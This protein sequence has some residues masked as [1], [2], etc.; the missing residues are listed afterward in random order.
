MSYLQIYRL[1][2]LSEFIQTQSRYSTFLDKV[3]ILTW[4]W[5]KTFLVLT[6]TRNGLKPAETSWNHPESTWNHLNAAIL[7]YFLLKISYSQVA[8]VLI[9]HPKVFFGQ[10]WYRKSKFSKLTEIWYRRT[11]LYRNF[12]FNVYLLKIFVIHNFLGKF[13]PKIWSSPN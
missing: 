2:L 8:F 1:R 13:G 12:E 5:A 6:K 11:F 4:Y 10:I 3:S 7:L 9:L